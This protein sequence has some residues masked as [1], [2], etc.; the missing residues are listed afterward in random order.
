MRPACIW[1][2]TQGMVAVNP[3]LGNEIAVF[4]SAV[5]VS[6]DTEV[7]PHPVQHAN[8]TRELVRRTPHLSVSTWCRPHRRLGRRHLST[9][10][11]RSHFR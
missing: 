11:L 6:W 7:S 2:A 4:R 3:K 9:H 10:K 1:C 5:K 8:M